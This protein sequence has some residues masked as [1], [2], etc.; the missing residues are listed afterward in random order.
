LTPRPP[1]P[2]LFPYT[3]LFRSSPD[4]TRHI[5]IGAGIIMAIDSSFDADNAPLG[6]EFARQR[7]LPWGYRK[8]EQ[9]CAAFRET[10]P[11]ITPCIGPLTA[12]LEAGILG[13]G[14][15]GADRSGLY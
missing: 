4:Q 15:N 3:T 1:R 6:Q 14:I 11:M 7:A 9:R 10:P 2:T 12:I 5:G 8:R 13:E